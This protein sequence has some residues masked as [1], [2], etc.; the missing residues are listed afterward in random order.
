MEQILY[1]IS[2]YKILAAI[3]GFFVMAVE[4]FLQL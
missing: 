1:S 3:V 4:T 2:E